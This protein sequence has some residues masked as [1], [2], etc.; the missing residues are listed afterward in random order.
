MEQY[1][2]GNSPSAQAALGDAA[3]KENDRLEEYN[4]TVK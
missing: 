4:S 3:K 1:M 2:N